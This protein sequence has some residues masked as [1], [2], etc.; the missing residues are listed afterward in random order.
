MPHSSREGAMCGIIGYIGDKNA[1][2]VI[3]NGLRRLEYRGYDSAG[4][5]LVDGKL[6][7]EKRAGKIKDL[8]AVICYEEC[9][10]FRVGLGHTRWATHGE[11]NQVNAHPHTDCTGDLALVHNGIIENY[12]VLR[13]A[14]A[15]EGHSF[16]SDTDTEV[17]AHLIEH[18]HRDHSLFDAV[19]LA[20][21][22]VEGTYGIAVISRK[23]PSVIVA[24]R[25]GSPLILGVGNGEMILAS[26]ASAIVEHTRNV[27]Y[28]E[29]K[30][31]VEITRDHFKTCD[32]DNRR[33][34][35][36]VE[37]I[38]WTIEAIEK[39]GFSHFMLKE[40]HEQTETIQDAFRGRILPES[41][42]VRL[43]GLRLT[44]EDLNSIE[45]IIFIACGTSWHAGLIGEYLI[46]EYARIPV[47][48]EY[49]SEF[50]YR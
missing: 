10:G 40:I 26:D 34:D 29:D 25:K 6:Y 19:L 11:P 5:A 18:Y 31:I 16:V 44:D 39:R 30:E 46:E 12:L 48:V 7:L 38:D 28:L 1:A 14:L 21:S 3:I 13:E 27:I 8:E 41:G 36:K 20:L 43:D 15:G 4:I 45:R 49:A 23:E 33:I 50:R 35:K 2:E 24:A 37:A 9:A 17:V 42:T 47:E 32:L 22:R